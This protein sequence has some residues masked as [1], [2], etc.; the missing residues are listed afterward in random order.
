M[1]QILYHLIF[2][3]D[4]HSQWQVVPDFYQL[5]TINPS[6]TPIANAVCL[7]SSRKSP[8]VDDLNEA[9]HGSTEVDLGLI[10]TAGMDGMF[11]MKLLMYIW[12]KYNCMIWY[13]YNCMI[14]MDGWMLGFRLPRA[15]LQQL[16]FSIQIPKN[17][18]IYIPPMGNLDFKMDLWSL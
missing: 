14:C 13:V 5:V 7:F 16:V 4:F 9:H 8:A 12:M 17:Q 11:V 6:K 15:L 18:M 2:P 10:C 3:K 1:D